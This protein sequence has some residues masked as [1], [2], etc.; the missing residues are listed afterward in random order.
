MEHR[1]GLGK[2]FDG[3]MIPLDFFSTGSSLVFLDSD[4]DFLTTTTNIL[5]LPLGWERVS[6]LCPLLGVW[7]WD[8]VH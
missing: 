6:A 1:L 8:W 2:A 7:D 3:W 5:T 4:H